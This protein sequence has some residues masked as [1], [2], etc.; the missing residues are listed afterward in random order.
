[1]RPNIKSGDLVT[2]CS[3][4][5]PVLDVGEKKYFG[6]VLGLRMNGQVT[7]YWFCINTTYTE[8]LI[9][10]KKATKS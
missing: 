3:A 10:L 1:M 7:V 2:F 4:A 9:N 5:Y 8:S 6:L